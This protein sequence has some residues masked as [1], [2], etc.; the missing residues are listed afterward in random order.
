MSTATKKRCHTP[1][2][3][4]RSD[5]TIGW[6]VRYYIERGGKLR[7]TSQT[8]DDEVAAVRWAALLDRVGPERAE[9]VLTAQLAAGAAATMTI[10]QW[11]RRYA[12]RLTGIE[13]ETRRKYVRFIERDVDPFMGGLPIG[14][15]TEE[16]DAAWVV[17]LETEVGNA[18][19]TICNK[20]G[21]VSAAM[22][23][24][25]RHR[26]EP[27]VPLNPC[28]HTR[29]PRVTGR[30][31][32]FFTPAEFELFEAL[33]YPRYRPMFEFMV[34]SMARPG[35]IF[36]L[37]VG[38]IDAETGAVRIDKAWKYA[39]GKRKLGRPK[40]ER[41]I[42]TAYVPLET[43]AKL[44]L[45]RP[46]DELLFATGVGSAFTVTGFYRQIWLPALRRLEAL[47]DTE[48]PGRNL[49]GRMAHWTGSPPAEL[50]ARFGRGTV[51]GLHAKW[52]T[53]YT[54]RHT[55]ISWRL[56]DGVPIWVVSRDAGHESIQ[57]TDRKYGHIDNASS[58]AAAER[59]AGRL[60]A[61]RSTVV[62]LEMARR[63]RLVRAGQLG[64]IDRVD[65]GF[66]A[67]W[68]DAAGEVCSRVFADYTAAVEH[69]ALHETGDPVA[70]AA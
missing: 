30:R 36:A 57:T 12:D 46:A 27:L 4:P 58:I 2:P 35:E 26:P 51:V 3:R 31:R 29:L 33:L 61:L 50:L 15:Y 64:E 13:E 18:P 6:Q 40:S 54:A 39:G 62:D 7:R 22:A 1:T 55:G 42:R 53:P 37:T 11:L 28:A 47:T 17:Y 14:A 69:V 52:L 56:Q 60:P 9:S 5:G 21:F 41:G 20:H 45:D 25:A 34:M 16:L 48:T 19:K 8:F 63:R 24:A 38:D 70:A 49:F 59:A 23:A 68:M 44:D 67:V 43:I 65:D 10:G 66:E 32:E